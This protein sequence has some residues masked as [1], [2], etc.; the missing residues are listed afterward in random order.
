MEARVS[1]DT[2]PSGNPRRPGGRLDAHDVAAGNGPASPQADAAGERA[3]QI[4][5]DEHGIGFPFSRGR[6]GDLIVVGR[7]AEIVVRCTGDGHI[8]S[9]VQQR[10]AAD[11]MV[12]AVVGR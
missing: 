9:A 1:L 4:R 5:A 7:I 12:Y 2:Q 11:R 3:G 10:A 6:H 8:S